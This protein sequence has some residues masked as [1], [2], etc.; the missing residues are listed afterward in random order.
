MPGASRAQASRQHEGQLTPARDRS[1]PPLR[2]QISD[3]A[4][5]M[6]LSTHINAASRAARNGRETVGIT[7]LDLTTWSITAV[8]PPFTVTQEHRRRSRSRSPPTASPLF[9]DPAVRRGS[10]GVHPGQQ[11]HVALSWLA[12]V[13][14]RRALQLAANAPAPL[15]L[16]RAWPRRIQQ[17]RASWSAPLPCLE[18]TDFLPQNFRCRLSVASFPIPPNVPTCQRANV[19]AC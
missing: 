1:K 5:V 15:F 11:F 12:D 16:R 13:F 18:L 8:T 17:K 14:E 3:L 19:P 2:T 7:N 9:R 6:E 10:W 4:A